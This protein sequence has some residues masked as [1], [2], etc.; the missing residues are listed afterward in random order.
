MGLDHAIHDPCTCRGNGVPMFV[1]RVERMRRVR[2]IIASALTSEEVNPFYRLC[3]TSSIGK[4]PPSGRGLII[5][6]NA[7]YCAIGA[8][9]EKVQ[10]F[11]WLA[12][13]RRDSGARLHFDLRVNEAPPFGTPPNGVIPRNAPYCAMGARCEEVQVFARLAPH[14]RDG[15]ARL[16]L[17]LRAN[18]QPPFGTPPN[19]VIPPDAPYCAIGARCEEV[20]VF[21]G[22]APHRRD[23]SARLHLDLRANE[24]PP[25]GTPPDR[26]VPPDAP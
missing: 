17:D 25:L 1:A 5:P 16:H 21:A 19:R 24:Q 18:E 2:R 14:R 23:S 8:R 9:C 26:I 3:D 10:V 11:T 7:P 13:H 6:R 20:Q 12:P 22:L 4:Q 15:G